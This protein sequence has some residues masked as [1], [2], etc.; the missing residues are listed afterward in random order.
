MASHYRSLIYNIIEKELNCDFIFGTGDYTVKSLDT[1]TFTHAIFLKNIYIWNS[2]WYFQPHLTK[3][4]KEYN[5]II[6]DLGILCLSSWILL[7]M[8]K[9]RHQKI[10][11]WDHGWYGRESLIKKILK[12]LYFGLADGAFIYGNY[13]RNLMIENGCNAKKLHT[14]HNSLDYDKQLKLRKELKESPIYY[15]YFHNDNPIICFIGRL[16]TVKRIDYVIKALYLLKLKN[17]HYNMV[18]IG[19]GIDRKTIETETNKLG[20]TNQIWFYGSC[21]DE[22]TNANLIYNADLCVSPGNVGLTAIHAMMF[23]CPVITHNDFKWQMPEFETIHIGHTGCFFERDNIESLAYTISMWFTQNKEK[24]QEIRR[25][26]F[27]EI[28]NH[29]NPYNQI[30]IIKKVIYESSI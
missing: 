4:T 3:L 9:L 13:A 6:N 27:T 7:F 12:R 20:L 15:N 23:G 24:R 25:A 10:Y 5:I 21:Y 2:H 29:W 18:I 8:A 14:I 30:E 17:I 28:D 16:T 11:H 1:T 22:K 26:C 19:D